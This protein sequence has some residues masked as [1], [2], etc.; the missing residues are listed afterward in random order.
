MRLS[1]VSVVAAMLLAGLSGGTAATAETRAGGIHPEPWQPFSA[2]SFTA[3]AGRYCDFALQV[4]AVQDEEEVRVDARYPDGAIRV[5]EYR[6]TLVSRFTNVATGESVLRDLSGRGFEE[7]Y[8]DGL[9]LESF[10]VIGPFGFGFGD[11]DGFAKGYYRLSGLHKVALTRNGVKSM[12]V[13][14]GPEENM[15]ETLG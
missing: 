15:C 5:N 11:G 12:A 3:P 2:T 10:T 9:T 14:A 7:R 1:A 8:P 13:D 4:T 6:G